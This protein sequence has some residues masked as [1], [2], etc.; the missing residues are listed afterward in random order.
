MKKQTGIWIDSKKAVII[1]IVEKKHTLKTIHSSIESQ[2]RIDGE[3]KWFTR[4][5][6]Q[7]LNFEKRK[8][9]RRNS[10]VK[11]FL[12]SIKS[13][14]K[15][16]DELVLFGPASMKKELAKIIHE[17]SQLSPILKGVKTADSMTDNQLVAWVKNYFAII[18]PS[19]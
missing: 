18:N 13:E 19:N 3:V 9:N 10:E 12:T 7:F 11:K 1:S 15:E 5:G 6:N 4:F 2:E 16:S 17:D 8:K 14:I